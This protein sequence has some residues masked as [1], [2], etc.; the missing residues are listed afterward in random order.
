MP[1]ITSLLATDTNGLAGAIVVG[2]LIQ[3]GRI[4]SFDYFY[5]NINHKK[6]QTC[7]IQKL[8]SPKAFMFAWL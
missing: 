2:C 3:N 1:S 8:N 7:S 5:Q 4:G 6:P